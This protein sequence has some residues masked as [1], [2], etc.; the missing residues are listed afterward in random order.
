MKQQI[1]HLTDSSSVCILFKDGCSRC[2]F[3]KENIF[4][5]L[6]DSL[7]EIGMQVN[8]YDLSNE[9]IPSWMLNST[10]L[11][12]LP[13]ISVVTNEVIDNDYVTCM[14]EEM[15]IFDGDYSE[16]NKIM[17]WIRHTVKEIL[18]HDCYCNSK[19]YSVSRKKIVMM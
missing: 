5:D 1:Y 6:L 18:P 9:Q 12:V 13:V 16:L 8:I 3:F 14:K 15:I 17:R 2:N 10:K 19:V 7:L 4:S 11:S